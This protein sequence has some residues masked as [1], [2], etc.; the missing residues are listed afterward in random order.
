MHVPCAVGLFS[1]PLLRLF[2]VELG[3]RVGLEVQLAHQLAQ[4]VHASLDLLPLLHEVTDLTRE[5]FKARLLL[6]LFQGFLLS[7][8]GEE[9]SMQHWL[10]AE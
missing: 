8:G 9:V 3:P 10:C 1:F 7:A 4:G 6:G 2:D 5:L